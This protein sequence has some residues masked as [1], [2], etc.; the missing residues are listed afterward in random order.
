MTEEPS[1]ATPEGYRLFG[2][3]GSEE[4]EGSERSGSSASTPDDLEGIYAF[5][6]LALR[7]A[8]AEEEDAAQAETVLRARMA[9][10]VAREDFLEAARLKEQL[11]KASSAA[12]AARAEGQKLDRSRSSAATAVNSAAISA[13]SCGASAGVSAAA[14]A[15]GVADA[16]SSSRTTTRRELRFPGDDDGFVTA[17]SSS[18]EGC[19]SQARVAATRASCP[20]AVSSSKA[21]DVGVPVGRVS[22]SQRCDNTSSQDAAA[23]VSRVSSSQRCERTSA[24]D[25]AAPIGTVSSSQRCENTSAQDAAAPVGSVSSSQRC[26]DIGSHRNRGEQACGSNSRRSGAGHLD[27]IPGPKAGKNCNSKAKQDFLAEL[28][29]NKSF[30]WATTKLGGERPKKSSQQPKIQQ[31]SLAAWSPRALEE[32]FMQTSQHPDAGA[33]KR[34]DTPVPTG[35]PKPAGKPTRTEALKAQFESFGGLGGT[36]TPFRPL[37]RNVVQSTKRTLA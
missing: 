7:A 24:Q 4:D 23:P 1:P 17:A 29:S 35:K 6:A 10:A 18:A 28:T 30:D 22:S 26:E 8:Q 19:R 31:Q 9:E 34:G 37:S 20:G 27:Q 36:P 13:T 16:A 5:D 2:R 21:E 25:V 12:A 14:D 32:K 11:L 3:Q 33:R 15:G